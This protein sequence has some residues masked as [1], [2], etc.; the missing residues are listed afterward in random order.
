MQKAIK[1]L[2]LSAMAFTML[3]AVLAGCSGN[4]DGGSAS[5]PAASGSSPAASSSASAATGGPDL[6]KH[7]DLK[8]FLLGDKPA[9]FDLVYDELNKLIEEDLNAS[10][11][12]EFLPFSD[13]TQ[14]YP[15]LF[16]SGDKVDLIY[17]SD[18]GL[19]DQ[20]A[21][22]GAFAEVTDEIVQNYMPMTWEKQDKVSFEQAKIGGK[23]YFVPNN[24]AA[25]A[26][27]N[28]IVI[29]GD[30]REKYGLPP[31]QNIDDLE[32]YYSAVAKNE[33]GI[34][35]YAAAQHNNELRILMFT[36]LNEL[37]IINGYTDY[38]HSYQEGDFT[39]DQ[40]Q[41]IYGS[42][43]YKIWV[44]KMKSW[45]DQGF[46]SK[47]AI[48]NK[49][50][51][52]D[53]F[54]NGTSASLVW[55]LGT[56]AMSAQKLEKEHPEWKPEVYDITAGGLKYRGRYTG[57]GMAV[58]ASSEN[59]DRA[60]MLIDKMK[61]DRRYNE[62][63]RLGIQGKHWEPEGDK[64][65][66]PGP[67]QDKYPFGSG[68]SWGIKNEEYERI[69]VNEPPIIQ[70]IYS[71]WQQRVVQPVTSGFRLDDSKIKAELAAV[72][73]AKTK[74]IPLLELGLVKSVD[75]TLEQYKA[76]AMK[77][78]QDTIGAEINAQLEAYLNGL[79]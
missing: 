20:E 60:F 2:G 73:S 26:T 64:Q 8:M 19:Y 69:S 28:A 23:A 10:L 5:A 14:R 66:K 40:V 25:L 78:G 39:V 32:A 54:E 67:N 57:D 11:R 1:K 33:Q 44:T 77:A 6:S 59:Q 16:A 71:E 70:Q 17:T 37:S 24:M 45:A 22:K 74:Y 72:N 12:V 13:W 51:P 43:P 61:F 30:L 27:S 15:L 48:S 47:N 76:D 35:P 55:N 42:E 34:F 68:G 79:N 52:R 62:L 7:V 63:I 75:E 29:R 56:V 18:W 41:W 31:I 50:Q 36:Q 9:E 21:P 46:W 4:K 65:W 58:A 3:S 38:F 49:T 53:A